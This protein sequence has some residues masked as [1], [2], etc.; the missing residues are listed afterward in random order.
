M[1]ELRGCGFVLRRSP[2]PQST[3]NST[4][5]LTCVCVA[6]EKSFSFW[7]SFVFCHRGLHLVVRTND[8]L[9]AHVIE[10]NEN[11]SPNEH[12]S[13]NSFLSRSRSLAPSSSSS[14]STAVTVLLLKSD[15]WYRIIIKIVSILWIHINYAFV[16]CKSSSERERERERMQRGVV[17]SLKSRRWNII[18]DVII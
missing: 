2:K 3:R 8:E 16:A 5:P 10:T 4:T 9:F 17:K 18:I 1:Q 6:T 14:S 13:R 7:F 11:D 15:I 12:F